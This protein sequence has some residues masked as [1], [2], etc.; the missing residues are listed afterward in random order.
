MSDR[1]P[2]SGNR[3][4]GAG[5][6]PGDPGDLDG[7]SPR[8]GRRRPGGEGVIGTG[9]EAAIARL[10]E[11]GDGDSGVRSRVVPRRQG[12]R[13]AASFVAAWPPLP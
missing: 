7:A 3:G 11:Y 1:E 4:P 5:V 9:R 13:F 2:A 8:G 10:P 6:A 12:P